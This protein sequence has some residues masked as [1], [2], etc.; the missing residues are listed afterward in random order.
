MT[1]G[2]LKWTLIGA[3]VGAGLYLLDRLCL[4]LE[5]RG[6]IFYRRNKPNFRNAGTAFIE[7]QAMF[8]PKMRH[9]LEKKEQEESEADEDESGD[10]PVPG[11]G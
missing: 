7:L 6:W 1:N 3:S 4:A 10:P 2:I 5:A 11:P 8:E 9:V